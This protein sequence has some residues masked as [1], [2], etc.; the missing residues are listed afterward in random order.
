MEIVIIGS[1]AM[2]SLFGGLLAE[3]G[4]DVT[5]VDIWEEHVK[6]MNKDGLVISTPDGSERS[7]DVNAVTDP[8]T[9]QSV[10]LVMIFVKSI[11]T[12]SAVK[13]ATPILGEDVDVLTV[14]NGL[15]NAETIAEQVPKDRVIGG[16]TSQGAF[17]EGPGQITHAGRGPTSIGRYFA[18]NDADVQEIADRFTAAGIETDITDTVQDAVWEKVLVNLGINAATALARVKNGLIAEVTSGRQLA[19]SAVTEGKTVAEQEGRT[20][21]DDIVDYVLEI[22]AETAANKSSMRQDLEGSRTT[23]IEAL[24]GEIVRRAERHGI[25]TPVN[26]TLTQL[27][28]LAEHGFETE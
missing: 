16:V 15:G 26:R 8:A 4:H 20:V 13:D 3:D 27:V 17:L 10:D 18:G 25:E 1:G 19:K 2:G 14:Q 28:R 6:A 12:E 9:V 11:H 24:N 21:R 22:A 5:L 23:E 7:I